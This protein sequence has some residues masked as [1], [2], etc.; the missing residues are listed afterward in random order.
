[1]SQ[2]AQDASKDEIHALHTYLKTLQQD[3]DY[4]YTL[5][6]QVL[7]LVQNPSKEGF[8]L[9]ISEAKRAVAN[10]KRSKQT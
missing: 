1:M 8:P 5:L 7:V 3:R 9:L 2:V 10:W 4:A 6:S